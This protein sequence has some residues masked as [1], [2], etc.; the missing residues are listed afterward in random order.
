[1]RSARQYAERR[2]VVPSEESLSIRTKVAQT[3]AID[4]TGSPP[5][6]SSL[7]LPAPAT[8]EPADYMTA[9]LLS[10]QS[11]SSEVMSEETASGLATAIQ[12]DISMGAIAKAGAL[13]VQGEEGDNH[14]MGWIS[15][16]EKKVKRD[17]K[18][19]HHSSLWFM[20]SQQIEISQRNR[21][22]VSRS[23][24]EE[25]MKDLK[26]WLEREGGKL[27][28]DQLEYSNS[29]YTH[30]FLA[31]EPINK[32]ETVVSVPL[33]LTMCRITSRNVLVKNKGSYLGEALKKTF[34][35]NEIWGLAIFLLHEWFKENA[36][37]NGKGSKWGPLINSLR[38]RS[39]TTPVVTALEGTTSVEIMKK[40][41]QD[42]DGLKSFSTEI[43]GPCGY[44]KGVCVTKP[45][46]KH[47]NDGRFEM[48]H[49]RWAYWVVVQNAV[50]VKH[51]ATGSTFLALV[52]FV[53][54]LRKSVATEG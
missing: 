51:K 31:S 12:E 5:S 52:P 7:S 44:T 19:D 54:T 4:G 1:M 41:L 26:S 39:L 48:H 46:E 22:S 30:Q 16:A 25:K 45:D 37:N 50:R 17:N 2:L 33:K 10:V 28:F 6:S 11:E 3:L 29:S 23:K 42:S 36:S 53:N 14:G 15:F 13:I 21:S 47:V 40:F 20:G 32:G 38:M 18:L 9:G 49:L 34:E 35:K 24:Q 8:H 27:S 43:D